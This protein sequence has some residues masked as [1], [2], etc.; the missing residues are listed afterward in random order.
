MGSQDQGAQ[1]GQTDYWS[2]SRKNGKPV[3]R[4]DTLHEEL[5][6]PSSRANSETL[7]GR[8]GAAERSQGQAAPARRRRAAIH[9]LSSGAGDRPV[10]GGDRRR[11]SLAQ[12]APHFAA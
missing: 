8:D 4:K 3:F 5:R 12:R 10:Q 2:V 1:R 9:H 11:V 7:G 6:A